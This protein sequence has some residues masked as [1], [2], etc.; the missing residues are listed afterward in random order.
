MVSSSRPWSTHWRSRLKDIVENISVIDVLP[1]MMFHFPVSIV[2]STIDSTD[3]PILRKL[4]NQQYLIKSFLAVA[5][6][7]D[8]PLHFA[9][10]GVSIPIWDEPKLII[11]TSCFL[12]MDL[13]LM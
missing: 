5:F 13:Y 1:M 10:Y 8:K 2:A 3:D 11:V 6:Y 4:L 12:V 9:I 7:L